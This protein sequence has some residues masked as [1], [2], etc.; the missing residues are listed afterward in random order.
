MRV[1]QRKRKGDSKDK[2]TINCKKDKVEQKRSER[3]K[4]K[5]LC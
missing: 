5:W 1:R 3:G 2:R 4:R